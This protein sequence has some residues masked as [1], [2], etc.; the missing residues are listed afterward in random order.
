[1]VLQFHARGD[2]VQVDKQTLI[3]AN[4]FSK[5]LSMNYYNCGEMGLLLLHPNTP[6]GG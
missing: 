4:V 2:V 3:N 6:M 1:V 5:F